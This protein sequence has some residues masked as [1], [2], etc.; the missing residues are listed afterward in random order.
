[1]DNCMTEQNELSA[2]LKFLQSKQKTVQ[3]SKLNW[4][5]TAEHIKSQ[6][7]DTERQIKEEYEKLHQFLRD[8]EAARIEAL[9]MEERQ[10]SQ[11]MK[12]K[13][14]KMSREMEAL[15]ATIRAVEEQMEAEDVS[16]IQNYKATLEREEDADFAATHQKEHSVGPGEKEGT[17]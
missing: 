2:E 11:M 3:E 13:I 9:R 15:S 7:Q 17:P 12:E 10:K 14:E 8:E 4:E 6:A 16:F 1:M 5:Q